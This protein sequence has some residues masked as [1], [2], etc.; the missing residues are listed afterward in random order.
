MENKEKKTTVA[1]RYDRDIFGSKKVAIPSGERTAGRRGRSQAATNL[2][3]HY[4]PE[5]FD[6]TLTAEGDGDEDHAA[7]EAA[8]QKKSPKEAAQGRKKKKVSPK[9]VNAKA[10]NTAEAAPDLPKGNKG[11]RRNSAPKNRKTSTV[12]SV[13]EK[14]SEVPM[15]KG[16]N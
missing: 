8:K 6:F 13:A 12:T 9:K 16:K 14:K 7:K 11:G 4:I 5:Q 15:N 2:W 3:S 1:Q 10:S